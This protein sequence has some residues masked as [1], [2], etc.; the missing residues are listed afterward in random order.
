MT[1]SK[2]LEHYSRKTVAPNSEVRPSPYV[3]EETNV[4]YNLLFCDDP[5]LCRPSGSEPLTSWKL[6]LF[7]DSPD[8]KAITAL[9]E[10][11]REESRV[12]VLAYNWLRKNKHKVPKKGLLGVVLE[13]P[14]AAG[15]DVLAVYQDRRIRYIN[16]T[17]KL[18]V[19]EGVLPGMEGPVANL[20]AAS[21]EAVNRIGPWDKP[22]LPPPAKGNIRMTFLVSNGIY[23][24]EGDVS[25]MQHDPTAGPVIRSATELVKLV[26][27]AAIK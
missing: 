16:Q 7:N 24:G 27:K 13:V 15:L 18:V 5:A 26:A 3:K 6:T 9:A 19:L 10:D 12:R 25:S 14:L 22:R 8:P 11:E 17:G 4:I 23:F 21:Q 20:L 2:S 1:C